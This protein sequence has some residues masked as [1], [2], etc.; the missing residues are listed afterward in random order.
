MSKEI[1]EKVVS[2]QFDNSKFESNCK[3]TMSTLDKLKSKLH[4]GDSSK[5]LSNIGDAVKKISMEPLAKGVEAVSVKFS[6]MEKIAQTAMDRMVNKA[7]DTGERMVKSLTV[8]N[9]SAGFSK[10]NDKTQS[11]QT[12][13]N[14][15]G[16][17]VEEI[18]NYLSRLMDYSDETSFSFTEMTSALS[19]MTSSGGDIKKLI[20]MIMG[21]ANATAFAG[22]GSA[23]FQSTIRNLS[24]SYSAGFLQLQDMK[25]LNLMGTSSKQLKETFIETAEELGKIEKGEVTLAN[26]DETLK[27][28]WADT[29]VMEKSLGKFSK[30]SQAVFDAVDEGT[31]ETA[32]KAIKEMS[33]DYDDLGV[34]AFA[35]AQEAKTFTEAIDATKDAVS[36]G[37]MNTFEILFGDYEEAKKLWTGLANTLY[38][39]FATGAEMR[40]AVLEKALG[41]SSKWEELRKEVEKTGASFD[42]FEAEFKKVAKAHGY[43]IE[44]MIEEQGSL[45]KVISSGSIKDLPKLIRETFSNF[46]ADAKKAADSVKNVTASYEHMQDVVLKVIR[47]DFS[48]VGERI[49]LMA[50]AGENWAQAQA[51]VDYIWERNGHTWNDCTF[52]LDEMNQVL[53]QLTD[54]EL[55]A[56]GMTEDQIKAFRDLAK[57]A[58]E[59]GTP[60]S[61]LIENMAKPTGK[62]LLIDS[63]SNAFEGLQ[64]ALGAVKKAWREIFFGTTDEDEIIE[65][66]ASMI[67]TLAENIHKLSEKLVLNKERADQLTRILK[68]LFAAFDIIRTV[69]GGGIKIAFKVLQKVLGAFNIDIFEGV[70][71]IGDAIVKFRDWIKSTGLLDRAITFMADKIVALIKLIDKW[72]I[73]NETLKKGLKAV[74][75][76]ISSVWGKMKTWIAGLKNSDNIPKYIIDSI[77]SGFSKGW[78]KLQPILQTIGDALTEFFTSFYDKLKPG[79]FKTFVDK[80]AEAFGYIK[81]LVAGNGLTGKGNVVLDWLKSLY[82]G[83]KNW[84]AGMK[85]TDNI[86]SY[87]LA[88]LINGLQNGVSNVWTVMSNLATTVIDAFKTILG[89]H[90]PSTVFAELGMYII[91]GLC[92][93]LKNGFSFVSQF[94]GTLGDIILTIADIVREVCNTILVIVQTAST[95]LQKITLGDVLSGIFGV[96]L[97]KTTDKILSTVNNVVNTFG[98]IV[99]KFG[100]LVNNFAGMLKDLGTSMKKQARSKNWERYSQAILNIAKAI[101]TVAGTIGA[102]SLLSSDSLL[103]ASIVVG[104]IAAVIVAMMIYMDKANKE[105]GGLE[106]KEF[107]NTTKKSIAICAMLIGISMAMLSMARVI[108]KLGSMSIDQMMQGLFGMV[109]MMLAVKVLME[110][111]AKVGNG[112]GVEKIGGI[113]IKIGIAMIAMAQVV[114]ALGKM[115]LTDFIQGIVGIGL[116]G[117][118]IVGLMTAT[119]MIAKGVQMKPMIKFLKGV[120]GV[121]IKMGIVAAILGRMDYNDF[122][123]GMAALVIFEA[124]VIGL[125]ASTKLM[126]K[127]NSAEKI[128]KIIGNISK[129]F[130]AMGACVLILGKMDATNFWQGMGAIT[131]F[132]G[133]II[134]LMAATKLIT[135][136]GTFKDMEALG[137]ILKSVGVAILL[138]GIT[139]RLIGGMDAAD[140]WSGVAIVAALSAI[141]VGILYMVKFA[142]KDAPK[143][144]AIL[145]SVTAGIFLLSLAVIMLSFID[146]KKAL[147][148]VLAVGA[149]SLMMALLMHEAKNATGSEK[150][151]RSIMI[152]MIALAALCLIFAFI[153]PKKLAIGTIAVSIIMGMLA[154]L[155]NQ[156][157][158]ATGSVAVIFSLIA[159]IIVLA[160][161]IALLSFLKPEGVIT[162]AIGLGALMLALSGVL[163]ILGKVMD[164]CNIL[165]L[166]AGVVLLTAL[167]IPLAGMALILGLMSF[168]KN[169]TENAIVLAGFVAVLTLLL[170]P[171]SLVGALIIPAL[172]GIAALTVL[173]VDLVIIVGIVALMSLVPNSIAVMLTLATFLTV[174]SDVLVK[175]ALVAP[176]LAIATVAVTALVAV[177]AVFGV[178]I[179][180]VGALVTLLPDLK[181]FVQNGIELFVILADGLGR[182]I[183]A[184]ITAIAN[185]LL[186]LIPKLGYALGE[187]MVAAT[188]FIVGA[189]LIDSD[190]LEGIGILALAILALTAADLIAGIGQFFGL[191]FGTLGTMLADFWNNASPFMDGIKGLDEATT[192]GAL[193]LAEMILTLTASNLLNG[194]M[195]FLGMDTDYDKFAEALPKFGTGVKA[196]ADATEGISGES[197]KPAAEAGKVLAEMC[198]SIP[199]TGGVFQAFT[200]EID[201]DKFLDNLP[202]FGQAIAEFNSYTTDVNPE[203]VKAAAE[204]GKALAEMCEAIPNTGGVFQ[205]FTGEIDYDGFL[206]NLPKFGQAIAEFNSFTSEIDPETVKAASEAGVALAQMCEEIPSEGGVFSVFT[207]DTDYD[208]F[209]DNLPKFGEAIAGFGHKCK[210]IRPANV[211][212][213]AIAALS[214]G[215]MAAALDDADMDDVAEFTPLI[216][217]LGTAIKDFN[218]ATSKIKTKHLNSV[219]KS[220]DKLADLGI[221]LD[222]VDTDDY[223]DFAEAIEEFAD[224]LSDIDSDTFKDKSNI[225]AEGIGAMV[226]NFG[227]KET[228]FSDAGTNLMTAF[229]TGLKSQNDKIKVTGTGSLDTDI[230]NLKA[231]KDKYKTAGTTLAEQLLSGMKSKN[232]N[233]QKTYLGSLDTDVDNINA[234]KE[235]FNEAGKNLA[236]GLIDGMKSKSILI[237]VED[238]AYNMGVKAVEGEKNGQQSHSPSKAT[239]KAGIWLGQGLI[240]GTRSM[241]GKVYDASEMMGVTATDG[242]ASAIAAVS[243]YINDDIDTQPT[244]R[245]V[246]DLSDVANGAGRINSLFN[247]T[248]TVGV[249]TNA[250]VIG[251]SM[252]SRQNGTTNDVIDAINRLGDV[253]GGMGDTYNINGIT[254][255]DGSNIYDAVQTLVRAARVERRT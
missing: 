244:I 27:K 174:M 111:T 160:G 181:T 237:Q 18:N 116:L 57:Q 250:R 65:K 184:F 238:A 52:T 164:K 199:K 140:A 109:I 156:S 35:S 224:I 135:K 243:E 36:S 121:F 82:D 186:D 92:N 104:V 28:K 69:V 43:D 170:L 138:M 71:R 217:P 161:A 210:N 139:V 61:E 185:A 255:D 251:N 178:L 154:L 172:L 68:G 99:P 103:K 200:G 90:S 150:V 96:A 106:L 230:E 26:F 31:Y 208:G 4:F 94:V 123:Q 78:G 223:E 79:F 53:G 108:K 76:F 162:A 221:K 239:Y 131:A 188:P 51:L 58:Q 202:L 75:T 226:D 159:I 124:L 245:P 80:L 42:D 191:S 84:F 241:F 100:T 132:T 12:L 163:F 197:V 193:N 211:Q 127:G 85:E 204:A 20:P 145:L 59:A 236:Q 190:V 137:G 46:T 143:I 9:I 8:D 41:G 81:N 134:G 176:L 105:A 77:A 126:A 249:M 187:F 97:F 34:R 234:K 248:P 165:K 118:L 5:G 66:R 171:L 235:K 242:I 220:L 98:S 24:Q 167:L 83:I 50:E 209:L 60:I 7:I 215:Q 128:Q 120:S 23:E 182:I 88:G 49:D 45:A 158:N 166:L 142:A 44:K 110:A 38:D 21:I 189:K 48:V 201:Y 15:T 39:I 17:S 144:G 29:E 148:G 115:K 157:K 22:K 2:M 173:L 95:E 89:I 62:E 74:G 155:L 129:A 183:G 16:L 93:G 32:T 179:T 19:Q 141:V 25:S 10:Y 227:G 30:F 246:L 152:T 119:K 225:L 180:A 136:G 73:H 64:I 222:D 55:K 214:L 133:I 219:T 218:S 169:A 101:A 213:A 112:K 54:E 216:G 206:N 33:K 40:N 107:V 253:P 91:E 86:G 6:A 168:A 146:P 228:T 63:F 194:I 231:K 196:F 195:D 151:V 203:T 122:K 117:G 13:V 125:I 229:L 198:E 147:Q 130:L 3:T 192:Q 175:L 37:W 70:A 207:G 11:V 252:N 149:L 247:G 212:A 102:L 254:Y 153:D 67:Y 1:D 113:M 240:N 232:K 72:V 47:G 233:I 14:S 114:K 177:L 205:A 56:T 87:I